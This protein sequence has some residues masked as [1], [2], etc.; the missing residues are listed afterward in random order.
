MKFD[1]LVEMDKHV[2]DSYEITAESEMA[3]IAKVYQ[4]TN[5]PIVIKCTKIE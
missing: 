4:I 1:V 3:A 2:Y 5:S